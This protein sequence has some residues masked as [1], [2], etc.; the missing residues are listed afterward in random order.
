M[1]KFSSSIFAIFCC[2]LINA[3]VANDYLV[4]ADKYFANGDYS[5]DAPYYEK[6]LADKGK[7]NNA[8]FNTYDVSAG[9]NKKAPKTASS[10][11]QWRDNLAES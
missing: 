8:G 5:S 7:G 1:K 9:A 11:E 10:R 3:Q 2:L 4:A 6:Y